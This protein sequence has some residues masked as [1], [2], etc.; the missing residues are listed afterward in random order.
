MKHVHHVPERSE[1]D[2]QI[3]LR[4]RMMMMRR[5]LVIGTLLTIV[6]RQHVYR[7]VALLS[8]GLETM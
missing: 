7:I 3:L 5:V 4:R 2:S 1:R 8:W 6:E